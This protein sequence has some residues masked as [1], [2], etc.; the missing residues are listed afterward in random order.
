MSTQL[1][2]HASFR[3]VTVDH[4]EH[5]SNTQALATEVFSNKRIRRRLMTYLTAAPDKNYKPYFQRG[6]I[7]DENAKIAAI[8]FPEPQ[9]LL[10]SRPFAKEYTAM[11]Y[12]QNHFYFNHPRAARYFFEAIGE[13]NFKAVKNVRFLIDGD[14]DAEKNYPHDLVEQS[15]E[16]RWVGLFCWL[17][18][19]H[20]FNQLD[21]VL[22]NL[23]TLADFRTSFRSDEWKQQMRDRLQHQSSMLDAI[24]KIRGLKKATL[25]DP[26]WRLLGSSVEAK[27]VQ[28]LMQQPRKAYDPADDKRKW[29][30]KETLAAINRIKAEDEEARLQQEQIEHEQIQAQQVARQGTRPR[31]ALQAVRSRFFRG[32]ASTQ[33][34]RPNSNRRQQNVYGAR[35]HAWNRPPN[36]R[37]WQSGNW[38]NNQD[39]D[40]DQINEWTRGADDWRGG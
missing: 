2:G 1:D 35:R 27:Q 26:S 19:R 7:Y 18:R 40:Q 3:L 31:S 13:D 8:A 33:Q 17:H 32:N 22:R 23:I 9:L 12:G 15:S 11:F 34:V 6:M 28:L 39:M 29:S 4:T 21:I 24:K 25:F 30:L 20:S 14:F 37:D 16:E 38:W 10:V 5:D 36:Q